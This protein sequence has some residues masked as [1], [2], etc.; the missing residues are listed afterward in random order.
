MPT[1]EAIRVSCPSCNGDNSPFE[2]ACNYPCKW[3]GTQLGLPRDFTITTPLPT[4]SELASLTQKCIQAGRPSPAP[5]GEPG[6][7][8][9]YHTTVSK[10]LDGLRTALTL[11][12]NPNGSLLSSKASVSGIPPLVAILTIQDV[13]EAYVRLILQAGASPNVRCKPQSSP[14]SVTPLI[15]AIIAQREDLLS[16]LLSFGAQLNS[17]PPTPL[18]AAVLVSNSRLV[19]LLVQHGARAD[20]GAVDQCSRSSSAEVM[21]TLLEAGGKPGPKELC[22]AVQ[23]GNLAL[24]EVL[25]RSPAF[26]RPSSIRTS[27]PSPLLLAMR[28]GDPQMLSLLYRHN[29]RE[30]PSFLAPNPPAYSYC[31]EQLTRLRNAPTSQVPNTIAHERQLAFYAESLDA[32]APA[33]FYS[34]NAGR[35]ILRGCEFLLAVILSY[36]ILPHTPTSAV[37]AW[38]DFVPDGLRSLTLLLVG[39][40][41]FAYLSDPADSA[42]QRRKDTFYKDFALMLGGMTFLLAFVFCL[43]YLVVTA[44]CAATVFVL[45]EVTVLSVNTLAMRSRRPRFSASIMSNPPSN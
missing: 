31:A 37:I 17:A 6:P 4:F 14:F 45:C 36:L 11:G 41:F 20:K 34:G 24:V 3:C 27:R 38:R 2:I 29:I 12:A 9:L 5:K 18:W 44:A 10:D 25:L 28:N 35:W 33:L 7:D 23:R 16:L 39:L 8:A 40:V 22:N 43:P 32:L 26:T 15:L 13:E 1:V 30:Y 21:T 42:T 19:R